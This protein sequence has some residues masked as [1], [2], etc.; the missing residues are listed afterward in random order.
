[1]QVYLFPLREQPHCHLTFSPNEE[2]ERSEFLQN[3]AFYKTVVH[4]IVTASL[5]SPM[6]E[7][8]NMEVIREGSG[9]ATI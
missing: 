4:L 6:W 5:R 1:M 2:L 8:H 7:P 9:K 3:L